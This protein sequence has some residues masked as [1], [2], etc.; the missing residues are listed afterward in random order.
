MV[1]GGL[2]A[3]FG[4][5]AKANPPE[6]PS[7]MA[8]KTDRTAAWA[9]WIVITAI[10]VG[11]AAG[12]IYLPS[13]AALARD[14]DTDPRMA[15]LTLSICLIGNGAGQLFYGPLADRAGRRPALLIGLGLLSVGSAGAMVAGDVTT[16]MIFRFVQGLGAAAGPVVGRG[17]LRDAVP[18]DRLVLAMSSLGL[19]LALA[20]GSAPVIGGV[21]ENLLSWR[22]SF[23]LLLASALAVA[24]LVWRRLPETL[25]DADRAQAR[26][27]GVIEGYR[28][29]IRMPVFWGYGLML[30]FTFGGLFIFVST[31]PVLLIDTLGIRADAYGFWSLLPSSGFLIGTRVVRR[32]GRRLGGRRLIVAGTVILLLAGIAMTATALA[33]ALSAWGLMLPMALFGIGLGMQ[34]PNIMTRAVQLEPSLAGTASSLL[35]LFQLGGSAIIATTAALLPHDDAA[36]LGLALTACALAS[37]A[38]LRLIP[39]A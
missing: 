16:L 9:F 25:G 31:A 2:R 3:G 19:A 36:A 21:I 18:P 4:A 15:Q 26:L 5:T 24:L 22:W 11:Q 12:T 28:V 23:A 10:I 14:L 38:C 33:A 6:F 1:G 29:F 34:V 37:L 8:A 35:G 7:P 39:R 20:P 27:T 13:L 17:V 30:T 32:F